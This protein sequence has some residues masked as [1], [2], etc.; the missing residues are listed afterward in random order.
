MRPNDPADVTRYLDVLDRNRILDDV[1][2]A[3]FVAAFSKGGHL[4]GEIVDAVKSVA[5]GNDVAIGDFMQV[6][7]S[8]G[9]RF[10]DYLASRDGFVA[11]LM[12]ADSIGIRLPTEGAQTPMGWGTVP[13][14]VDQTAP[15]E[16]EA[17]D[18]EHEA[19]ATAARAALE[20]MLASYRRTA[21]LPE[22]REGETLAPVSK[23][24]GVPWMAE[25]EAWPQALGADAVFVLQLDVASLPGDMPALLGGTGLVQF[26]YQENGDWPEDD[27][28]DAD[29]LGYMTKLAHVRLVQ[30]EG[31]D[32]HPVELAV[33]R[34]PDQSVPR[35]VVGWKPVDDMPRDVGDE[36]CSVDLD[37]IAEEFDVYIDD[38]DPECWQGDKLGGHP[39]WTQARESVRDAAGEE[40]VPFYQVDAGCFYD[41]PHGEAYAPALFAGDGTG[42]LYVSRTDPTQLKFMWACG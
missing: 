25:G 36:P 10:V 38:I 15:T 40:M 1:T 22:V 11:F 27:G 19:R 18:P 14:R 31:R 39:F 35:L 32:G 20:P 23:Y 6:G 5:E 12:A 37:A 13:T 2:K 42:H 21:W 33:S 24:F 16:P 8:Q 30:P 17:V 29:D 28:T 4:E 26:F 9:Q 34:D 7:G 3:R 41:G